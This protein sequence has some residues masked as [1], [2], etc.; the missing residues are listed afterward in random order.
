M[1]EHPEDRAAEEKVLAKEKARVGDPVRPKEP[2]TRLGGIGT[3]QRHKDGAQQQEACADGEDHSVECHGLPGLVVGSSVTCPSPKRI[4]W[5]S[6]TW[7]FD[8]DPG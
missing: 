1:G 2:L 5:P 6:M 4:F 3:F 8:L 7:L